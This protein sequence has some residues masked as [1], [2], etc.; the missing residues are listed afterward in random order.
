MVNDK[1][2][3]FNPMEPRHHSPWDHP[4]PIQD[5]GAAAVQTNLSC[6]GADSVRFGQPRRIH[7]QDEGAVLLPHITSHSVEGH[8]AGDVGMEGDSDDD[9]DASNSEDGSSADGP[10]FLLV[11][12]ATPGQHPVPIFSFQPLHSAPGSFTF[13]FNFMPSKE[14]NPPPGSIAGQ[15]RPRTTSSTQPSKTLTAAQKKAAK[16]AATQEAAACEADFQNLQA[17]LDTANGNVSPW[18]NF[19]AGVLLT[20]LHVPVAHIDDLVNQNRELKKYKVAFAKQKVAGVGADGTTPIADIPRPRGERGRAWHLIDAMGLA[21][22][23]AAYHEILQGV[24]T[25]MD[26]AC[27]DVN[28]SVGDQDTVRLGQ[29]IAEAKRKYPILKRFAGDW[30]IKE[31]IRQALNNKRKWLKSKAAKGG[32]ANLTNKDLSFSS[33]TGASNAS[34]DEGDGAAADATAGDDGFMVASGSASA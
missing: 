6:S 11:Q 32:A 17:K 29:C 5:D 24:R 3:I 9:T 15:K 20:A 21:E 8:I 16:L 33:K 26:N 34:D 7:C 12:Q 4:S 1:P 2:V 19:A 10:E 28:K 23:Y 13:T 31:I 30:A 22:H 25:A 18:P 27:L 14:N